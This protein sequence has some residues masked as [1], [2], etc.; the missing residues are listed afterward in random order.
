MERSRKVELVADLSEAFKNAQLVVVTHYEGLNVAEI[1]ELRNRIRDLDAS[2][3]VTKNTLARLALKGTSFEGLADHFTG[4]TAIAYSSDPVVAAK[5]VYEFGKENE[6]LKLI[7]GQMDEKSLGVDD[8]K[9]LASLPSLDAL[10]GKL[11]GLLQAPAG[12]IVGVLAAPGGGMARLF[13]A[14]ASKSE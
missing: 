4:P 2:F 5:A 1:T 12:K 11:V 6:K 10:R 7:A 13:S 8:I 3:M 14:Y 9:T